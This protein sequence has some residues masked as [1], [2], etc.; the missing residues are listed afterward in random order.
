MK[1]LKMTPAEA[2]A[3]MGSP[4]AMTD[5]PAYPWGTRLE[6]NS[7]TLKKIGLSEMPAIGAT[8][9]MTA[10]VEVCG[11]SEHK[12]QDGDTNRSLTLQITDLEL[13]GERPEAGAAKALYPEKKES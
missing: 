10:V 8:M 12:E 11:C 7:A 13:A 3:Q 5:L 9:R 6:L 2:K 4:T 1:S